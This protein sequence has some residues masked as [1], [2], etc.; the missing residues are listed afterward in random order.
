MITSTSQHEQTATGK[1]MAEP[2]APL[3]LHPSYDPDASPEV[4]G[5]VR[6][7]RLTTQVEHIAV[8]TCICGSKRKT[9]RPDC[10][11]RHHDCQAQSATEYYDEDFRDWDI[12]DE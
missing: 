6:R 8:D 7:A 2:G 4:R 11:A 1:A 10:W 3:P 5:N 9:P 12:D